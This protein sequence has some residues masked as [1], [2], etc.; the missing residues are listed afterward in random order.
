MVYPLARPMPPH[1]STAW[2]AA[3]ISRLLDEAERVA[4]ERRRR[5]AMGRRPPAPAEDVDVFT[6][7]MS[8]TKGDAHYVDLKCASRNKPAIGSAHSNY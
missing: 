3:Q 2:R 5:L 6:G 8:R 1:G 7:A 4:A